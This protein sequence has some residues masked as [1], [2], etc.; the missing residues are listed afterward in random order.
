MVALKSL[1]ITALAS[2]AWATKVIVPLYS[3]NEQCWPELQQAAAANPSQQF[4]LILNPDSGPTLDPTDPS[5]YCVPL[6]RAKMPSST[7]IGYVRT[8]FGSRSQTDVSNEITQYKQWSGINVNATTG[9]TAKLDGIFFDEVSDSASSTNLKRY[10]TYASLARNAFGR[11]GSA[12]VFNPGAAVDARFYNWADVV[13]YYESVYADYA[14]SKLPQ[15]A[16]LMAK[17]AIVIHSF[18]TG[19]AG[20]QLLPITLKPLVPASGAVYITDLDINKVDVYSKFGGDWQE[21]VKDVAQLN[22]DTRATTA[23]AGTFDTL[24]TLPSARVTNGGGRV[25]KRMRRGEQ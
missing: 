17:S 20:S 15:N 14:T 18:P 16:Q 19:S 2:S 25:Q 23:A 7:I 1:I 6:L 22:G 10:Q 5:M 9:Q 12:V 4:V 13:M 21:F 11:T 8:G 24:A 3:W